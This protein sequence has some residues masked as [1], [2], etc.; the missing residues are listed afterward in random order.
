[1]KTATID[2]VVSLRLITNE[3]VRNAAGWA[4]YRD[5]GGALAVTSDAPIEG[6]NCLE[7]FMADDRR[8]EGL[9]D[10][11]FA[12]LRAFDRPPAVRL[13]PLDRPATL[14]KHL[15]RRRLAPVERTTAMVFRGDVSSIRT[16]GSVRVH[17]AEPEDA[18]TFSQIAA[19][20]G[21]AKRLMLQSVMANVLEP[22]HIFYI[23]YVGDEPV[24][25]AR[26]LIDEGAAGIYAVTT[27]RD[28]RRQGVC[29]TLVAAA[30]ER[31]Q[32]DGCDV[33][34]LRTVTGGPAHRLFASL[35]FVDAHESVVW[36]EKS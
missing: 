9:L 2:P 4:E 28:Y 35:G 6:L 31:A 11:G 5:L 30:I 25:T 33:V 18:R 27:K 10:I 13:T 15:E 3:R 12:L 32:T 20:S 16:N 29:S 23:G 22:N 8:V 36:S 17:R 24:G 34:G 19:P 21:W 1:M 7:G 26:L 14:P